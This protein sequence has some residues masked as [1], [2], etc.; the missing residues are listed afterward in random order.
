MVHVSVVVLALCVSCVLAQPFPC[1]TPTQLT[2]RASQYDHLDDV[3]NR[4]V[5]VYD[6]VNQRRAI[7]EEQNVVNPGRQ[8]REYL[9]LN[10]L[11]VLY[12]INLTLKTCRRSV[13]QP[14]RPYGIPPNATFETEYYIGGPGEQ[15]LAQ[16]W[17][18]RIPYRQREYW[19]GAFSVLNCYPIREV[20]IANGQ[21]NSTVSTNFY[22]T[23][24]GILNPDDFLPPAECQNATWVK[25]DMIKVP[26]L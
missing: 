2:T 19:I 3:I 9:I 7:F 26:R 23:V 22:D 15:L 24:E 16:E 14:W 1:V 10:N 6:A 13:P 11:N 18:D 17:S 25:P 8:F 5:V 20:I 21:V 4:Y 12:E